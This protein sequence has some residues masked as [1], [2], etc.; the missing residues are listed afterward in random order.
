[1]FELVAARGGVERDGQRRVFDV[2]R[3]FFE[4]RQRQIAGA[5]IEPEFARPEL[6]G[7]RKATRRVSLH[8]NIDAFE[9]IR[10]T[11]AIVAFMMR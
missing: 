10:V 1:M 8:R 6:A 3:I 9:R 5:R 2:D 4:R 7:E 11:S